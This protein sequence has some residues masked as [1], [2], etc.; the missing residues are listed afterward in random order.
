MVQTPRYRSFLV[1]S[2]S[3]SFSGTSSCCSLRAVTGLP[4]RLQSL[5]QSFSLNANTRWW[6]HQKVSCRVPESSQGQKLSKQK[7]PR[8]TRSAGSAHWRDSRDMEALGAK[9]PNTRSRRAVTLPAVKILNSKDRSQCCNTKLLRSRGPTMHSPPRSYL[10][11]RHCLYRLPFPLT[12][13][14]S[15]GEQQLSNVGATRG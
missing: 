7:R 10:T 14:K 5:E 1:H 15:E 3:E 13:T 4:F 6:Q 9:N 12:A 11:S 2:V 8:Q